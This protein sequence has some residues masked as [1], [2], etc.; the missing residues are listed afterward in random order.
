MMINNLI[1]ITQGDGKDS[2][3]LKAMSMAFDLMNMGKKPMI[4][5]SP[6]SFA[7]MLNMTFHLSSMNKKKLLQDKSRSWHSKIKRSVLSFLI[8]FSWPTKFRLI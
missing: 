7:L 3:K 2:D 1:A 8:S 4:K 5:T 6:R